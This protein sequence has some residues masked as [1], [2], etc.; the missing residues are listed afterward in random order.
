VSDALEF[1]GERANRAALAYLRRFIVKSSASTVSA[2]EFR[3]E[4]ESD[5]YNTE[6]ALKQYGKGFEAGQDQVSNRCA[7]NVDCVSCG[8]KPYLIR[9][10]TPTHDDPN[11]S[12]ALISRD[13]LW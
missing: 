4:L 3:D 7:G 6:K 10:P 12:S 9:A 1:R 5:I 13:R 11:R 8:T 2:R